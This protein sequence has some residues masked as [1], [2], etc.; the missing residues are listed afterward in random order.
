MRLATLVLL[1]GCAADTLDERVTDRYWDDP[2][3]VCH[4]TRGD[5]PGHGDTIRV[6]CANETARQYAGSYDFPPG[7]LLVKEVYAR[8]ADQRGDLDVIEIMRRNDEPLEPGEHYARRF[9]WVFTT[10]S[11]RNGEETDRSDFCW[12]RCH[13]NAPVAGAWFDY[14]QWGRS[15]LP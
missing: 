9:G 2:S 15:S 14:S 13:A 12:R 8:R 7:S 5:T 11:E 1:A 10:T 3:W 6:I 4:E